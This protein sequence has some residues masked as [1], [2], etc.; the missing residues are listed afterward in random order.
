MIPAGRH[1]KPI[2]GIVLVIIATVFSAMSDAAAKMLSADLPGVEVIWLRYVCFLAIVVTSIGLARTKR[3]FV[4]EQ[5]KLQIWRGLLVIVSSVL[6]VT[7]LRYLS[8]SVATTTFYISPIFVTALS[9]LF[10]GEE[11]GRRRW[12]ATV[13]G[14]CGVI[15][16]V[17]PGTSAFTLAALL[18]ICSAVFWAGALIVTRKISGLEQA[19]TTLLYTAL[20]GLVVLTA[21]LPFNWVAPSLP[22]V[23]LGAFI[24]VAATSGQWLIIFA[25]RYADASV[26]APFSYV[27]IIWASMIGFVVFGEV[28]DVWS[29]VGAAIIMASGV[30]TAHRER[31]RRRDSL[32]AALAA[33]KPLS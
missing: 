20:V 3:V 7:G 5:P 16:V 19:Q 18:P 9:I 33:A 6:F 2:I 32:K 24:G 21:L 29:Y 27:Q 26:L 1:D 13:V 12:I 14:L 31:I 15:L 23:A 17:R 10:L 25:Y 8:I 22:N 28:S 30:Y 11:V 4:T